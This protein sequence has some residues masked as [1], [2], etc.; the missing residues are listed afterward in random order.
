M[1]LNLPSLGLTM[2]AKLPEGKLEEGL[3]RNKNSFGN[4]EVLLP[5]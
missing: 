3:L 2:V 5:S 1:K 4:K